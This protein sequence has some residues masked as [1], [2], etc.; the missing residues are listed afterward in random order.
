MCEGESG[1]RKEA[2]GAGKSV[3]IR[4][5]RAADRSALEYALEYKK[6]DACC[7]ADFA[8]LEGQFCRCRAYDKFR[9]FYGGGE[10]AV[11]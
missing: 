9:N 6:A 10:G 3:L 1:V 5:K 11:D 4:Q 8:L 7:F 2:E